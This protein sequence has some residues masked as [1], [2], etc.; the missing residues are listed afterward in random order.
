MVNQELMEHP[1]CRM[2]YKSKKK[3]EVPIFSSTQHTGLQQTVK[4]AELFNS[5]SAP[6]HSAKLV[7]THNT[8]PECISNVYLWSIPVELHKTPSVHMD[9]KSYTFMYIV[10]HIKLSLVMHNVLSIRL[11]FETVVH[12][13]ENQRHAKVHSNQRSSHSSWLEKKKNNLFKPNSGKSC[14]IF[15]EK[16]KPGV[17]SEITHASKKRVSIAGSKTKNKNKS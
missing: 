17:F 4:S 10:R 13:R 2:K 8:D 11:Y 14:L 7:V 1:N 9:N 16:L 6:H 15:L 3:P 12:C 5:R